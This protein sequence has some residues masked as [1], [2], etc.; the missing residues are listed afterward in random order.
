ML[1]YGGWTSEAWMLS[2]GKRLGNRQSI[3]KELEHSSSNNRWTIDTNA[4][5]QQGIYEHYILFASLL[6]LERLRRIDC[7][8]PEVRRLESTKVNVRKFPEGRMGMFYEQGILEL[9]SALILITYIIFYVPICN[10][11]TYEYQENKFDVHTTNSNHPCTES[12]PCT[13]AYIACWQCASWW[14]AAWRMRR[15]WKRQKPPAGRTK[16]SDPQSQCTASAQGAQHNIIH[17][18]ATVHGNCAKTNPRL[19]ISH[20]HFLVKSCVDL[21]Q[22]PPI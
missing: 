17:V 10:N 6:H 22:R 3:Q 1:R 18:S 5:Q 16:C 2:V 15:W 14:I 19:G 8:L 4:S 21:A 13:S 12:V 7:D 11:C 20:D 9:L